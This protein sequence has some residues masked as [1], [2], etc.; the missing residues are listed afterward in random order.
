MHTM[1]DYKKALKYLEKSVQLRQQSSDASDYIGDMCCI[2]RCWWYLKKERPMREA[3]EKALA[4]A[5]GEDG[6]FR[7]FEQEPGSENYNCYWIGYIYAHLGQYEKAREYFTRMQEAPKCRHCLYSGCEEAY[8]GMGLL[9]WL[10]GD[11]KQA[12]EYFARCLELEPME[13]ECRGY[14]KA[15]TQKKR[16]L[17]GF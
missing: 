6:S 15:L 2:G 12:E 17:F 10:M 9:A 3:F 7:A 1:A 13:T 4:R 5:K 8:M 14:L 16:G 11:K